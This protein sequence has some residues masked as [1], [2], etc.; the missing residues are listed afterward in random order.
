[1]DRFSRVKS[2][3]GAP[4]KRLIHRIVWN[5]HNDLVVEEGRGE[6]AMAWKITLPRLVGTRE[7]ADRLARP[8]TA[9]P[10]NGTV[11]LL[12]RKLSTSTISFTDELV[13]KLQE[14]GATEIV[15]VAA[16]QQFQVQLQEVAERRGGV[17]VRPASAEEL[18]LV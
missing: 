16:P 1:M 18:A 6:E 17:R 4:H 9:S 5:T 13:L 14:F 8:D 12:G 15:T 7:A 11:W 3:L 2:E 10:S